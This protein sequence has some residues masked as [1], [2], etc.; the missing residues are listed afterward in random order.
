[1]AHTIHPIFGDL[2]SMTDDEYTDLDHKRTELIKKIDALSKE[3]DD[4][5]R[6]FSDHELDKKRI[7]AFRDALKIV[8]GAIHKLRIGNAL[9]DTFRN[10]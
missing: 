2:L 6:A 4:P 9:K 8:E 10:G 7:A 1:M 5:P 3:L